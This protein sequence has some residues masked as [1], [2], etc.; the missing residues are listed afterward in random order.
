VRGHRRDRF[1]IALRRAIVLALD[2]ASCATVVVVAAIAITGGGD[3]TAGRVPLRLRS[4]DNPLTLLF[5]LTLLRLACASWAPFLLIDRLSVESLAS[6]AARS[7]SRFDGWSRTTELRSVARTVGVLA[8]GTLAVKVFF[9]WLD[10]GFFSGDDVEIHEMTLRTLLRTSWPVWDLRSPIY[11]FVFIYP[12]QELALHT[13]W[14]SISA[15]VVF[16]RCAVAA[17]STCALFVTFKIAATRH[18][19]AIGYAFVATLFLALSKLA[20][21]FGSTELPRPISTV[22]V[23]V[24]FLLLR[25]P[26]AMTALCAG[27]LLGFAGSLRF[28]EFVF[29]VPALLELLLRRRWLP[30]GTLLLACAVIAALL[31][32]Y[33]DRIYWGG[34]FHSLRAAVDFTLVSRL[35]SRGYQAPWWYLSNLQQWTNVTLASLAIVGFRKDRATGLWAALALLILSALPHKEARYAIPVLPF[36]CLLAASGLRAIA[37][38]E[39]RLSFQ[40]AWLAAMLAAS[41]MYGVVQDMRHYRLPRSNREVEQLVRL[42]PLVPP[43][44]TLL[45]EQLWRVGGHLYLNDR[46][47]EDLYPGDAGDV[48]KLRDRLVAR[49]CLFIDNRT[50]HGDT[51]LQVFLNSKAAVPLSNAPGDPYS[52]WLVD[53]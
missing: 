53:P 19:D 12:A 51:E 10:P 30:A 16:G 37:L 28:S 25:R 11:P 4:L 35:S 31:L 7:F 43:E 48:A 27:G 13:P 17:I 18:R 41:L 3:Y 42:L 23:L 6:R 34:W 36:V 49:T 5:G 9:A 32:G 24:A 29:L 14:H 39:A 47:A 40:R 50:L 45:I 46:S 2:L 52:V 15:L 33:A 22:F 20:I 38:N 21:S 8:V 1:G 44:R 26:T